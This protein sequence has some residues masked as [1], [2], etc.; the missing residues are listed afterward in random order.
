GSGLL[1]ASMLTA[2]DE[3]AKDG[4]VAATAP[5]SAAAAAEA[6][7]A[8]GAEFAG[9]TSAT[10]TF[11]HPIAHE[12]LETALRV[13]IGQQGLDP[14]AVP[15]RLSNPQHEP[16]DSR[17]FDAW[18]LEIGLPLE[19]AKAVLAVADEQFRTRPFFPSSNTI[20]GKVA[21]ETQVR[22]VVA[23]LMSLVCIVAYIWLRFQRVV[24]GLAAVVALVH[25]VLIT[26]GVIALSAYVSGG[27]A[28]LMVDSFKIG[29]TVLAAL[30]T[31]IGYSL[32]DTIVVF[33][34]IREV[35][36]KAPQ[37][38]ASMINTSINQTLSRTLLTSVT[39]LI[40]VVILYFGGGQG[41]HTFAFTLVVGVLVGTYS[42]IFIAS[43]FLYWMIGS[44]RK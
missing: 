20:G 1:L 24:F 21:G 4:D 6:E 44:E 7:A 30:L 22:A 40:V 29:L 28:F 39:T 37:L 8:A 31:I 33:D 35:R 3:P 12:T 42:S 27:L 23:L 15:L 18:K 32:N 5:A 2:A 14:D 38:T 13:L 34:R 17:A 36:G 9:G 19:P 26:V 43:P 41:I 10:L 16:G 25:D 11:I